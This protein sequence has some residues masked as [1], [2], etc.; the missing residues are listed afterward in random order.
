MN[1]QSHPINPFILTL[2]M[3]EEAATFFNQQRQKYFPAHLNFLQAHLTLFHYLPL[4]AD[5]I[6]AQVQPIVKE[7]ASFDMPVT[8]LV[9]L[10]NGVAYKLESKNLQSLHLRLQQ[11]WKPML[12]PQDL[13]KL[14]PHITVQN[15]VISQEANDLLVQLKTGFQAFTIKATGLSVWEYLNGPWKFIETVPFSSGTHL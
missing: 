14:W 8:D 6:V 7:V 3:N 9:S 2:A 1:L 12:K 4:P 11:L 13:Q 5:E 15:K 10:G